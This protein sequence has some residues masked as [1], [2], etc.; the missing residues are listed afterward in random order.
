LFAYI[1]ANKMTI[2][3]PKWW[4]AIEWLLNTALCLT[5]I[6]TMIIP[7]SRD[8]VY[9]NLGAAFYAAFHRVG[10]SI[11]I[12]WVIWACV[13]GYAGNEKL[14]AG[15]LNFRNYFL[16]RSCEL[17]TLMEVLRSIKQA[18]FL[19]LFGAPGYYVLPCGYF[20]NLLLLFAF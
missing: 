6:Y 14:V 7:Y 17:D 2:K 8:Y 16:Y 3:M 11:G 12:G 18:E 9:E 15:R 19:R 4:V 1:L 20:E 5:L 10:W 13:N